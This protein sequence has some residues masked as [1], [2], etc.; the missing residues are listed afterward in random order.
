MVGY[1]NEKKKKEKTIQTKDVGLSD[2][3]YKA[4]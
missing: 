4:I 3:H 2:T 1:L